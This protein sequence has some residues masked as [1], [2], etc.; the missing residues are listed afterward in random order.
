MQSSADKIYQGARVAEETV[1]EAKV[2]K[3]EEIIRKLVKSKALTDDAFNYMALL[4]YEDQPKNARELADL[5]GD[6]LTDGLVHSTE[7]SFKICQSLMKQFSDEQL[8]SEDS[9]D[10]IIA[11]KLS[12]PITIAELQQEG[13]SGVVREQD[14]YD[15]L[16]AD[17]RTRAGNFNLSDEKRAYAEKKRM[18]D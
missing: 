18:K 1:D 5:I 2:S 12:K 4:I 16:L 14:F 3:L 17:E 9:R 8:M 15:P 10:T 6:F 7:E 11:E 13:H